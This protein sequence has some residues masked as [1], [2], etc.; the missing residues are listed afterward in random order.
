MKANKTQAEFKYLPIV[1]AIGR[2][3]AHHPIWIVRIGK[4]HI[5]AGI[6]RRCTGGIGQFRYG[7]RVRTLWRWTFRWRCWFHNCWRIRE[8]FGT[9]LTITIR[10]RCRHRKITETVLYFSARIH[11]FIF[12]FVFPSYM[13]CVCWRIQVVCVSLY[14]CV[15]CLFCVHFKSGKMKEKKNN[16]IRDFFRW[17]E[18]KLLWCLLFGRIRK[19]FVKNIGWCE[20][21]QCV[22]MKV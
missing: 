15:L 22:L 6:L 5:Y 4:A 11:A 13:C 12:C 3:P 19:C 14:V 8:W 18:D 9:L 20:S 7:T 21:P 10:F 1:T 17:G 16:K 2:Q